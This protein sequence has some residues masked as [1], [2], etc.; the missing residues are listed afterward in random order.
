MTGPISEQFPRIS[1]ILVD[2]PALRR[3]RHDCDPA[4]CRN[5]TSCCAQ[6]EVAITETE[7]ERVIGCLP[8]VEVWAPEV[9]MSDVYEEDGKGAILDTDE[10]GLCVLAYRRVDGSVL[11][12]LH[13]IALE[14][15][16]DPAEVKPQ[17]CCLWP[18]A[19][20]EGRPRTL[21]VQDDA[22]T[23]PCNRLRPRNAAGL[24]PGVAAILR[25]CFGDSFRK[26]VEALA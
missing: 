2:I 9:V 18:L 3:L 14:H 6:Y 19:L 11:C 1:G 22:Y 4:H 12:S 26:Q 15:G 13:S 16:L 17:C 20:S 23:F 5:R 25:S 10:D 21:S 24:D 8:E 7:L